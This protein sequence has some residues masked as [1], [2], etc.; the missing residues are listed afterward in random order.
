MK[1]L[2]GT[3]EVLS[4][5]SYWRSQGTSYEGSLD[6]VLVDRL[7]VEDWSS[8]KRT[9]GS[10]YVVVFDL[11]C[12]FEKK[13]FGHVCFPRLYAAEIYLRMGKR[14]IKRVCNSRMSN[15]CCSRESKAIISNL[16]AFKLDAL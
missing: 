12:E 3:S 7:L 1:V 5:Y 14:V 6:C 10:S 15:I 11:M 8:F 9:V 16:C 4:T 13:N 2:G